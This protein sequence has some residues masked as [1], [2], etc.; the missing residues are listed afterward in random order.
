M[1]T[2]YG[3]DGK[4]ARAELAAAALPA[5]AVWLDLLDPTPAEIAFVE[6]TAGARVPTHDDLSEIEAS[7]RLYIV[8]G[9]LYLSAPLLHR[10]ALERPEVTPVGFVLSDRRLI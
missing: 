5:D 8:N 6:R 4:G 2:L 3:R 7:S 1:L 10:Q 9:A